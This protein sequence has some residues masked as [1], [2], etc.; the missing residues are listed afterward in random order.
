MKL[1]STLIVGFQVIRIIGTK[2]GGNN[3]NMA[4]GLQNPERRNDLAKG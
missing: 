3:K 1:R 2:V 4:S